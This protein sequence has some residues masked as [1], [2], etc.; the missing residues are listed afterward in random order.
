[1]RGSD[2]L[3]LLTGNPGKLAEF[4]RFLPDIRSR[5]VDLPE[6]QSLDGQAIIAEKLQVA[7]ALYPED[8]LLVE[9]TSLELSCFGGLPGPFVKWFEKAMG[10]A[11]MAEKA[12]QLGNTKALARTLI[13]LV[14]KDGQTQFFEGVVEGDFVAPRGEQDFGWGP[15]FQPKGM[16]RTFGEMT[17]TEK[18]TYSMRAKAIGQLINYLKKD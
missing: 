6:I 15:C 16:D 10:L 8:T 18:D 14:E 1:M 2:N 13:G 5:E 11:D 9:D 17:R 4:Q 12:R 7:H 3:Y